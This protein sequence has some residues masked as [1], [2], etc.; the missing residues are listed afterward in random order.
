VTE[1]TLAAVG[2]VMLGDDGLL[3]RKWCA[4]SGRA[5]R[6]RPSLR[7]MCGTAP[8]CILELLQ[9]EGV[10]SGCRTQ[11]HLRYESRGTAM[12]LQHCGALLLRVPASASASGGKQ[13]HL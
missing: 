1:V 10:L 11:P 2:D 3:I 9:S 7:T 8:L 5:T 12:A 13:P 4:V 6:M